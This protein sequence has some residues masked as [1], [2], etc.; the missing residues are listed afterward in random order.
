MTR[1]MNPMKTNV[2]M[3]KSEPD[4]IDLKPVPNE[5]M[6]VEFDSDFEMFG[7]FGN[8]SGFCYSLHCSKEEAEVKLLTM[9]ADFVICHIT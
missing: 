5:G 4:Y 9:L 1:M 8:I 6:Y 3:M 2:K 7:I